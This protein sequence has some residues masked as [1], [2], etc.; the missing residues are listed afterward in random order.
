MIKQ[1]FTDNHDPIVIPVEFVIIHHTATSLEG[2]LAIFQNP[3]PGVSAHLVIAED[4]D[5]YEMVPCLSGEPLRAWHA[6]VSG[7][8]CGGECFEGFNEF[9]IG[10]ELVNLDGN[11]H[12]Y[13]DP[14][15]ESLIDILQQLQVKYPKLKDTSRIIGHQDIASFRGKIDPGKLFPWERVRAALSSS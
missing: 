12:A 4:G 14:Q 15:I 1:L 6:G 13:P 8:D 2:T 7:Y 3:V 9:S 10:I 5:V 11:I